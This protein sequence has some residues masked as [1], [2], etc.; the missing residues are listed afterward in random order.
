[1]N[2]VAVFSG[3]GMTQAD[4]QFMIAG[5]D[6]RL[7]DQYAQKVMGDLRRVPGAVDVDSSLVVGKPQYGVRS[8]APRPT[9]WASRSPTWPT[10]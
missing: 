2:P 10:R 7:L 9:T 8:T 5:P 4:V 3:G 1:M 6:M